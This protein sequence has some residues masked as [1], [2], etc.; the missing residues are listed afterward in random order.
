MKTL[1]ALLGLGD[2]QVHS[3]VVF[4]GDATFKTP[5]PENVTRCAGYLRYIK[6]HEVRVLT[7]DE[8]SRVIEQIEAGRLAASFRTHREHVNNGE[9]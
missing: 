5:M 9:L 2:A 6:G 1:Q 3:L 8:V 4:V 7:D